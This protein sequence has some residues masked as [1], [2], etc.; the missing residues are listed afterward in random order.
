MAIWI[1]NA[2][3]LTALC[4]LGPWL[5]IK[6]LRRRTR[7]NAN[8]SRS[9]HPPRRR[10]Q[11]RFLGL[12]KTHLPGFRNNTFKT[13]WLHGVSV[14]EVQLL[15]P[16]AEALRK[17]YPGCRLAVS[18]TTATGMEVACRRFEPDVQLFYFPLDF[19]WAVRRTLRTLRPDLI[20]LG[21]LELWPNLLALC[22]AAD[23]PV[24]V[25][26]G[27]LSERSFEGYQ[28]A[29]PVL[30]SVFSG[31]S[32][33]AAQTDT[34]AERFI[35]CGVSKEAVTVTGSIKFD[36]A[37]TDRYHDRAERFRHGL[38]VT[39]NDRIVVAGSTQVEEEQAILA[40]YSQ[41]RAR[42]GNTSSSDSQVPKIIVVPR[43]AERFDVVWETVQNAA[44][45]IGARCL[46]RSELIFEEDGGLV[47]QS[48]EW[49]ILLV[50]SLGELSS[51]WALADI[52]LVGGTFGARGGQNMIEPAAYGCDVVFG[53]RSENFRDVVNLLLDNDA[54]TRLENA[55]QLTDFLADALA[56]DSVFP[57]PGQQR[58][59]RAAKL[60]QK[61][62]GALERT[63]AV[64]DQCLNPLTQNSGR[65]AA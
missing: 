3:Y 23:I 42:P 10:W 64:V 34:Y 12:S 11:D 20:V 39:P 1:R 57:S 44:E 61:Q 19:S 63:L 14:G 51:W 38:G 40:A 33:V 9:P 46:R 32:A 26:N 4:L 18:T 45:E 13:I 5:L 37:E 30:R 27:R 48:A 36:N 22:N 65:R 2:A 24:G 52:A 28:R 49:D 50:D 7:S 8:A 60:V 6:T 53:P 55:E 25:V 21:E 15:A 54:A 59:A 35:E 62:C 41:L 43:H 31:L 47:R 58:G 56:D 17:R 29:L 16:I